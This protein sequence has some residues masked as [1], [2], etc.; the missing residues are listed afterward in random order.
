[1]EEK[2]I[3][4]S[5][6]ISDLNIYMIAITIILYFLFDYALILLNS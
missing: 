5:F 6:Q 3:K 2:E 1:M 4:S